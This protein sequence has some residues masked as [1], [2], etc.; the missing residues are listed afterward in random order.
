MPRPNHSRNSGASTTR[1]TALSI[2]MYG[3]ITRARNGDR[4]SRNPSDTPSAAPATSPSSDSS[5]VT[6]RWRH[7]VPPVI[8]WRMRAPMSLGR[9]TKNGSRTP[10]DT[11]VCHNASSAAPSASCDARTSARDEVSPLSPPASA[12]EALAGTTAPDHLFAQHG[13]DG[14]IQIDERRR[15]P[16]LHEIAR[17]SERD[18]MLRDHM[19]AGAGRQDHD[20]VGERDRFFEIMRHEHYGLTGCPAGAG[21]GCSR[22]LRRRRAG[23]GVGRQGTVVRRRPFPD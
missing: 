6:A 21:H 20:L 18:V 23:A 5:I 13:P 19:G 8:H 3:S 22:R 7:N 17:A 16:Q 15:G 1:G 2:L 10:S 11:S 4:A 9:L 12:T 14:A